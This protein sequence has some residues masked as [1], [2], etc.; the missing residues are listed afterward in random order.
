MENIL[1]L[2][3]HIDPGSCDYNEWLHCGMALKEEGC[4]CADWDRWSSRD[5]KRYHPGECEKKWA[6][7]AGNITPVTG[8]TI[9]QIAVSK[10]WRPAA[11]EGHELDWNSVI[12]LD[13]EEGKFIDVAYLDSDMPEEPESDNWN[14]AEEI[15]R[16]LETLFLPDEKVGYVM[17]SFL[18]KENGKEKYTPKNKGAFDR[19]AGQLIEELKRCNNDIC[20]VL[21][22]YDGNAGAWIRF[23]PLDGRG[24]KNENVTSYRYALVESDTLDIGRQ[25][26]LI[27]ELE[28]PVAVLVNSGEKSLHAIVRVDAANLKEYRSRVEYLYNVCK[29]NGMD[30]DTQNKNPSRLSRMPGIWRNKRKQY[31]VATNIGQKNW[32]AWKEYIEEIDDNLPDVENLA[33]VWDNIPPLSEPLIENVLRQGHKMLLVGPSKAGKTMLQLE[34]CI[35]I[36][37]G[38]KWLRWQCAQGKVMYVNL[39]VDRASCLHRIKE[40][41]EASGIPPSKLAN[42]SIWPL[43]GKAVPMDKL[44]GKLIRRARKHNYKAIIIDPIYKVITGD[45]NSADQMAAFCNYFD[46]VCTELGCAVIYCHHH[47]K[48]MQGQKR[49][50]DRASG[51]GVFARDPDALLDMIQLE[52]NENLMEQETNKAVCAAVRNYLEAENVSAAWN[53]E[54]DISQDDWL[55]ENALLNLCENNLSKNGFERLKEALKPVKDAIQKATAWRMEGTLREFAP[56]KPVNYWFRYPLHVLDDDGPLQDLQPEMETYPVRKLKEQ[57]KKAQKEKKVTNQSRFVVAV[58]NLMMD[59]SE[60]VRVNDAAAAIKINPGTIKRWFSREGNEELKKQFEIF[61][62]HGKPEDH[63]CIRKKEG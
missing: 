10:G 5:A 23:N 1:R 11:G 13:P 55:N 54:E 41:Y 44:A 48:G 28:L 3:E 6:G 2:L 56:F 26:A 60:Y 42:I 12:S 22:D 58:E 40:V 17:E 62:E 20:S 38:R 61:Q 35:A 37:E 34:L 8:G 9:Y 39:E 14:Q 30:P 52:I 16:Y 57:R 18:N 46:K 45:E 59:G 7:F 36:A 19:T 24:V 51:S 49:S 15:I 21:G 31:I 27:R 43:R 53:W 4:S 50:M 33:D 25:N 29:K 63:A 32:D 47:S